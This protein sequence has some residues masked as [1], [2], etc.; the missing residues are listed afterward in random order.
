MWDFS[1][2]FKY[3]VSRATIDFLLKIA[4]SIIVVLCRRYH[5]RCVVL[6]LLLRVS[7]RTLSPKA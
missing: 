3:P 2:P 5:E 6:L 7:A 4:G 1:S